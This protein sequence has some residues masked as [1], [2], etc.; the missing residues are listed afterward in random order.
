MNF[1][2]PFQAE[3]EFIRN[4]KEMKSARDPMNVL[5]YY[6]DN[7]NNNK[8]INKLGTKILV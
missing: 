2:S 6:I 3:R 5:F 1:F 7:D 4:H 8:N